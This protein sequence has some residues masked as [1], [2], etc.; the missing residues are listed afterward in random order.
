MKLTFLGATETVTGSKYLLESA[1]QKILIDC[2]LF[3]GRKEL[4]LRNWGVLPIKSININAV[5]L[6]HAHLDHSGYI[7]KLVNLGF[8]G[9][10]YC[11]EATYDLCKILLPDSGYLQ[12]EDANAAN[13]HGWSKHHPAL[14]LYTEEE[15]KNS[16][17]YF[18]PIAFGQSYNLHDELSFSFH[19]AGHIL[20][21]SFIRLNNGQTNILFSGDIGRLHNPVMK[22]PAQIQEIDYLVLESTY[23]N[24]LHDKDDPIDDIEKIVL[25]TINR[26]GTLLIPSFAVGRA[27]I[28]LYYFY[29]L[30]QEKRIPDV[31]IYLD[32]PMAIDATELLHKHMNDHRLSYEECK[33]VCT[34]PQYTRT[35]EE[36]KAINKN[37]IPKIIISSSGMATGGRILHHLKHYLGDSKNTILLSGFQAEGTRGD[38][39]ARGENEIKIHGNMWPVKA[40]IIKLDNMSAH[41]D[42]G[43]ILIWLKNFRKPIK[44]VFIT[45]GEIEAAQS[46]KQ[47]IEKEFKWE[48]V[49]PTY[50]QTEEL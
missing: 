44:K 4:R 20:G 3:Q 47:K 14:P 23:G 46:L 19:R 12:E 29:I 36:S 37:N 5:L 8:S 16:L 15:A 2:G 32:S 28:L 33:S 7:P 49:I 50:M 11:T 13:R 41:A 9:S 24:R 31:P 26:G 1:N 27:Q 35:T 21:A 25:Q 30:K 18:R 39:L 10:I 43:E 34:I 17:Q 22:P 6:T 42:Y 38:R 48:V 40:K 45:H